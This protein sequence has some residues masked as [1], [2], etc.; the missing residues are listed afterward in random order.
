MQNGFGKFGE[1]TNEAA[2]NY[3]HKA[4]FTQDLLEGSWGKT[5]QDALKKHPAG[6]LILPFIK[7][8]TNIMNTFWQ[9]TPGLNLLN[10]EFRQNL[11]YATDPA[12]R[13]EALGRLMIGSSFTFAAWNMALAGRITGGGPSNKDEREALLATG[14]RPYSFVTT[15]DDGSKTYIE[16]RRLDPLASLF[17]IVAD[18]SEASHGFTEMDTNAMF[19]AMSMSVAKNITSRTYFQGISEAANLLSAPD[20]YAERWLQTRL[21]SYVPN[22]VTQSSNDPYLRD[23]R[24]MLDAIKRR[25]PGMSEE[26][27]PRRNYLGEVIPKSNGWAPW[28]SD[29]EGDFKLSP[30]AYSK[31]IGDKTKDELANLH[32]VFSKPDKNI[33][34]VDLTTVKNSKNP[35]DAYDRY[36]QLTGEV[37]VAGKTLPQTLDKLVN[38]KWYQDQPAPGKDGD[39]TNARVRAVQGVLGDYRE[40]A[41][42]KLVKEY[43]EIQQTVLA[44]QKARR[45]QHN[46]TIQKILTY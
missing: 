35:Y 25:I 28:D 26:L 37:Q 44:F 32:A 5:I 22:A 14:W 38:S 2:L 33:G 1:G 11:F 43:P 36:Q 23:T 7:T 27:A 30:F 31:S 42:K 19:Q 18:A 40:A 34:P 8:P 10:K 4:T 21:G 12:V 6:R 39:T 15:N 3:A 46:P 20:R 17:G 29:G 41:R 16:Y 9:Y 13:K 45:M 24:T